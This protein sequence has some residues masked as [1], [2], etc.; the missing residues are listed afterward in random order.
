MEVHMQMFGAARP[1]GPTAHASTFELTGPP[2][3]AGGSHA[4]NMKIFTNVTEDTP[5]GPSTNVA[6][7]GARTHIHTRNMVPARTY[8]QD[9]CLLPF[10]YQLSSA[11]GMSGGRFLP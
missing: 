2:S 9:C 3:A 4:P 6:K 10:S 1:M 7:H 5:K 11:N 8:T